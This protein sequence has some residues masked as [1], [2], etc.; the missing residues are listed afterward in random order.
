MKIFI[1]DNQRIILDESLFELEN[2]LN[3]LKIE[4]VKMKKSN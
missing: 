4:S 2:D 1:S 3:E